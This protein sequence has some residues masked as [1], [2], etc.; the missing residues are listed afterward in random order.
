MC[1]F[2]AKISIV[3]ST[4][5]LAGILSNGKQLT[6]Y[7]NYVSAGFEGPGRI[8]MR[9]LKDKL[10]KI[11]EEENDE[12]SNAMILP[13]PTNMGTDVKLVNLENYKTLFKDC[14]DAFPTK[15]QLIKKR[16]RKN[17]K[18]NKLKVHKVGCYDVSIAQ[19][20]DDIDLIDEDVFKLA[21]NV[22]SLLE[23]HYSEN[24][25][26]LI[27]CFN[28]NDPSEKH[29]L[30]YIHHPLPDNTL[31]IPTRHEH[32][33]DEEENSIN[34]NSN[35]NDM[36]DE[37][38]DIIDDWDHEIFT[39]NT[40]KDELSGDSTEEL[41]E[42]LMESIKNKKNYSVSD[43]ISVKQVILPKLN[44]ILRKQAKTKFSVNDYQCFRMKKIVGSFKN[45]DVILNT[46]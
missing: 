19:S 37:D 20:L 11:Q 10:D 27:C 17:S 13:Y 3:R 7:S 43:G 18:K 33:K 24:F 40:V 2:N 6:V 22:R 46:L 45:C 30:G 42:Q 26:F 44:K 23:N 25:G 15:K 21:D 9:K 1:I 41:Y 28:T 29:P 32:H 38:E 5:L 8:N 14:N 36:V 34:E 16:S 4:R 12:S 35:N 31:F 39:L